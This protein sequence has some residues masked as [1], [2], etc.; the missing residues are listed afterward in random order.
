[1]LGA[2]LGGEPLACPTTFLMVPV[3][4]AFA[5]SG[6]KFHTGGASVHNINITMMFVTVMCDFALLLSFLW[7]IRFM[8]Y[9]LV[10]SAFIPDT[11][12][13]AVSLF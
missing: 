1:M 10:W 9:R 12:L 11:V 13:L 2:G 6:Y 3:S 5:R 4:L 7:S 8:K